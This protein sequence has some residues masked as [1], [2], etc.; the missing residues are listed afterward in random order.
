[1][2]FLQAPAHLLT[3]EQQNYRRWLRR[4]VDLLDPHVR[5]KILAEAKEMKSFYEEKEGLCAILNLPKISCLPPQFPLTHK[6]YITEYNW[7][8]VGRT[9][10]LKDLVNEEILWLPFRGL[11]AQKAVEAAF[12]ENG[13]DLYNLQDLPEP[14]HHYDLY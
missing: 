3:Y 4:R 10:T 13:P 12:A 2:S 11:K 1:M 8:T 7:D 14:V 5:A 9:I 6:Q